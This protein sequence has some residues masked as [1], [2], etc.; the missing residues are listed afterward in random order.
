MSYFGGSGI[1]G[2]MNAP[3]DLEEYQSPIILIFSQSLISSKLSSLFFFF[4]IA[5]STATSFHRYKS[6]PLIHERLSSKCRPICYPLTDLR[7]R[8]WF[9]AARLLALFYY[10]LRTSIHLKKHNHD[11]T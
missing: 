9:S 1:A 6:L 8:S 2:P 3:I 7:N 10:N 4:F 5:L 11:F